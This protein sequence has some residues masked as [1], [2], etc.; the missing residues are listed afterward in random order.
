MTLGEAIRVL[1]ACPQAPP[2]IKLQ[3][4]ATRLQQ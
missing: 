4:R 1:A 3:Q 2:Q